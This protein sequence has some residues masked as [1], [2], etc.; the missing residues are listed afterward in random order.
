[1]YQY[2]TQRAELDQIPSTRR[3][4]KTRQEKGEYETG[5]IE[6]DNKKDTEREEEDEVEAKRERERERRKGK[7]EEKRTIF[8]SLW[9]GTVAVVAGPWRLQAGARAITRYLHRGRPPI[10]GCVVSECGADTQ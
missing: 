2:C 5:N 8:T 10:G 4:R 1:M 7:K 6:R 9:L 3:G